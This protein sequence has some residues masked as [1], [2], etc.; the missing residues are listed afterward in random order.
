VASR[1]TDLFLA[2]V[3]KQAHV[4]TIT[5]PQAVREIIAKDGLRG[6]FFRGLGTRLLTN[7]LQGMMFTVIWRFLEDAWKQHERAQSKQG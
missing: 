5:Y 1:K 3:A 7:G 4:S 6:L 2:Q